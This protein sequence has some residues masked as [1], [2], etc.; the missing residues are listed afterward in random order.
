[1][2]TTRWRRA[3]AGA[4]SAAIMTV[5]VIA[6]VASPVQAAHGTRLLGPGERLTGGQ[7]LVSSDR[8]HRLAMQTDGNLVLYR[9]DGSYS[10]QTDTDGHPGAYLDMQT[11][12]NLVLYRANGTFIW[13][14]NTPGR[15]GARLEL[16]DDGNLVLLQSGRVLWQTDTWIPRSVLSP[17][18][19][20]TPGQ[21]MYSADRRHKLAMQ[22]DGNLVLY[23]PDGSYSWQTD[24]DG[25]PGAYLVMQTD[26]NLVMYRAN[27]TSL[28]QTSTPGRAGAHLVLQSDGNLVLYQGATAIWYTDT[29]VGQHSL[30]LPRGAAPRSRYD[31]PHHDYPAVD[32]GVPTGTPALAVASGTVQTF[33]NAS[34]GNGATLTALGA[35]FT[36][37]HF[38][39]HRVGSGAQVSAGQQIGDTGNTGNSTGPHLHLAIQVGGGSRCPQPWLLA[40]YDGAAPPP[41]TSLPTSGCSY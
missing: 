4:V 25:H 9:P 21:D 1:M 37:C 35:V 6:A 22:T 3:V 7:H 28:W 15:A 32:I 30:P 36:Y 11:D 23:R 5:G 41:V 8:Q 18:E 19:R 2:T 24:T 17:G 20:L 34:C 12:G 31:D 33:Y 10:W 26:G 16:Q 27:N 14:T 38:S 13:Q 40:V 29:A 39:A